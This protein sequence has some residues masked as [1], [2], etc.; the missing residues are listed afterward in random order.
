MQF[1]RFYTNPFFYSNY[2]DVWFRG[3]GS[4]VGAAAGRRRCAERNACAAP[5]GT[6]GAQP[7]FS[8]LFMG[9]RGM[10]MGSVMADWRTWDGKERKITLSGHSCAALTSPVGHSRGRAGILKDGGAAK[11]LVFFSQEYTIFRGKRKD[12]VKFAKLFLDLRKFL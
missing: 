9:K 6:R 7:E 10:D 4:A 3:S 2:F 11:F 1:S 5:A 12:F 8:S